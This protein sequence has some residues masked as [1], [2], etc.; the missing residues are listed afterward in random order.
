MLQ[1]LFPPLLNL[2]CV[3][4]FWNL[5]FSLV[6]SGFNPNQTRWDN[7]LHNKWMQDVVLPWS[8]WINPENVTWFLQNFTFLLAICP[9]GGVRGCRYW[10][11][12]RFKSDTMVYLSQ[13]AWKT[14]FSGIERNNLVY[15]WRF[16]VQ[17]F[18]WFVV[19]NVWLPSRDAAAGSRAW[20]VSRQKICIWRPLV[21]TKIFGTL[22]NPSVP[23]FIKIRPVIVE[24]GLRRFWCWSFS[25]H[26]KTWKNCKK[27]TLSFSP[28]NFLKKFQFFFWRTASLLVVSFSH[29]GEIP[30]D[31]PKDFSFGRIRNK[32]FCSCPSK[33]K[34]KTFF[35]NFFKNFSLI[36]FSKKLQFFSFP[37]AAPCHDVVPSMSIV[38]GSGM[39][40]IRP[41]TRCRKSWWRWERTSSFRTKLST[42]RSTST[43]TSTAMTASM[44]WMTRRKQNPPRRSGASTR[45]RTKQ[46][47]SAWQQ[48]ACQMLQLPVRPVFQER[49]L[50]IGYTKKHY[51]KSATRTSWPTPRSNFL[52]IIS[53]FVH[54][55]GW[56]WRWQT[57]APLSGRY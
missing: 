24:L 16:W 18:T 20:A 51:I 29:I 22:P 21:V 13:T 32:L 38:R 52:L 26:F 37:I 45:W 44:S 23:S 7:K 41:T 10:I 42:R 19:F 46:M 15:L 12:N 3:G 8:D 34:L 36:S 30:I 11:E 50:L 40:K 35:Q 49:T 31:N 1:V 6:V 27:K 17:K 43:V 56:E 14:P 5:W 9:S 55:W 48:V 57:F 39:F 47:S 28:E 4:C 53:S 33:K 25:R 54:A 2:V